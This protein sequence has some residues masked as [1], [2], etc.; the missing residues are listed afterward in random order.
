MDESTWIADALA[1]LRG[2]NFFATLLTHT[3][4]RPL[5]VLPLLPLAWLHLPLDFW[6]V[7]VVALLL[8]T[9]SLG[10]TYLTLRNLTTPR[11]AA[12][13]LLPLLVFYLVVQFD[14]FLAYRS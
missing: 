13:G 9:L 2:G 1:V 3:T 10:L 4:A 8:I 12:L 6:H 7:K 5:T 11:F 14:D